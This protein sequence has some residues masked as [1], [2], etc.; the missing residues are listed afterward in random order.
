LSL[1]D[2]SRINIS[3]VLYPQRTEKMGLMASRQI[4][5]TPHAE[6]TPQGALSR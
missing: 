3:S 6:P 2:S 1:D 4:A 5:R